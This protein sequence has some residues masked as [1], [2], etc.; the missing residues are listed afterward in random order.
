[1]KKRELTKREFRRAMLCGLGRC[2]TTLEETENPAKYSDSVLWA[3]SHVISYDPQCEGTRCYYIRRLINCFDDPAPFFSAIAESFERCNLHRDWLFQHCASLLRLFAAD[4]NTEA[5]ELL[6]KKYERLYTALS[7]RKRRPRSCIFYER[8]AFETLCIEFVYLGEEEYFRIA[9]DLGNLFLKNKLYSADDFDYFS[10]Q[11]K[12]TYGK[13]HIDAELKKRAKRD[14]GIAEYA[15]QKAAAEEENR[16]IKHRSNRNAE[17]EDE[18]QAL[19]AVFEEKEYEKQAELLSRIRASCLEKNREFIPLLL[20]LTDSKSERVRDLAFGILD[21]LKDEA[22]REFAFELYRK[23]K[24]D[25]EMRS[26][27]ICMILNNYEK[28]DKE[29]IF[30]AVSTLTFGQDKG[31]HAVVG[32]VLKLF[33]KGGVKNPPKELLRWIYENSRCSCCRSYAVAK[34]SKLRM[35]T[36]ELLSECLDDSDEDI[37]VLAV[38]KIKNREKEREN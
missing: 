25:E 4:G 14:S 21:E 33:E 13:R 31:W 26:A 35:L 19:T 11:G 34:M 22:V 37:N 29:F 18:K 36:D 2:A 10:W 38:Q 20:S 3:C 23:S 16:N 7:S 32:K 6:L 1:M 12:W 28:E 15:R 17:Q 27:A 8:D 9:R 24:T 30:Q 5:R